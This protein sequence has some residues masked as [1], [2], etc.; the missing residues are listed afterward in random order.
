MIIDIDL[1][2]LTAK[3]L[4]FLKNLVSNLISICI[5]KNNFTLGEVYRKNLL[6]IERVLGSRKLE[7]LTE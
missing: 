7:T 6:G 3:E 4:V 2:Y 1:K 5:L